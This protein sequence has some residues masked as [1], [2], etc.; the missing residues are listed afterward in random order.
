MPVGLRA[1]RE[2]VVPSVPGQV[3]VIVCVLWLVSL[4][5]PRYASLSDMPC[6][7]RQVRAGHLQASNYEEMQSKARHWR[8]FDTK[9]SQV[10]APQFS[11]CSRLLGREA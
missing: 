4:F 7:Q 2:E 1:M 5:F 9:L 3:E 11:L 6:Q 10:D 8:P